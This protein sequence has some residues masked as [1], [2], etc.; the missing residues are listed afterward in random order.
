MIISLRKCETLF[1]VHRH[2]II[3]VAWNESAQNNMFQ[4]ASS[5]QMRI[6]IYFACRMAT[7]ES[8]GKTARITHLQH[9]TQSSTTLAHSA[10][11]W[12]KSSGHLR[13]ILLLCADIS[14]YLSVRAY[15]SSTMQ[16]RVDEWRPVQEFWATNKL[17]FQR[18]VK[19]GV[20][21]LNA[22]SKLSDVCLLKKKKTKFYSSREPKWKEEEMRTRKGDV[23]WN[24]GTTK[25]ACEAFQII[26]ISKIIFMTMSFSLI[27]ELKYKPKKK[28]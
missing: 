23:N 13:V 11:K 17:L 5:K 28:T 7:G 24:I 18:I 26:F 27:A 2:V 21:F 3:S 15:E 8:S 4:L 25:V 9:G 16:R 6:R 19:C 22:A 10:Y 12:H 20:F 14:W 1:R